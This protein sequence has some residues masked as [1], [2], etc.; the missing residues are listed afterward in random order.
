MAM[1]LNVF[2]DRSL[3]STSEWQRAIDLEGFPLRLAEDVGFANTSGLLPAQL[4]NKPAGF[5]CYHDNATE[6]MNS[7]GFGH[8]DHEWR[9]SLGLRWR[10]GDLDELDSAWM[11]ATAYAA[12]TDGVIFDYEEGR[13]FTVM[14]ARELLRK[15]ERER[16]MLEA[17]IKETIK[18][19]AGKS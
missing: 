15:F 10:G 11:A 8:F 5:E 6:A 18:K 9:F 16:P 7:L 4:N 14:E 2:S 12:A 3:N 1:E 19:I 13:I 17:L